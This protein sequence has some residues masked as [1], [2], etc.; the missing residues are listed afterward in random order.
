MEERGRRPVTS[1]V[2]CWYSTHADGVWGRSKPAWKEARIHAKCLRSTEQASGQGVCGRARMRGAGRGDCSFCFCTAGV[3]A[4]RQ[5][6]PTNNVVQRVHGSLHLIQPQLT[7]DYVSLLGFGT[8]ATWR[9]TLEGRQAGSTD[10]HGFAM[11]CN[12]KSATTPTGVM[13]LLTPAPKKFRRSMQA[14]TT[15]GR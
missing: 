12:G 3:T 6:W 2:Q 8:S 9:F 7:H 10:R 15:T 1:E 14:G 5:T 13:A 4:A 11:P